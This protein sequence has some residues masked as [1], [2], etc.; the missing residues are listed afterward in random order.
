MR[1]VEV[2]FRLDPFAATLREHLSGRPGQHLVAFAAYCVQRLLPSY[3]PL[4]AA[5]Y[6]LRL[7][8][9]EPL[10]RHVAGSGLRPAEIDSILK[11]SAA[12]LGEKEE[13]DLSEQESDAMAFLDTHDDAFRLCR[14]PSVDAAALAA[15]PLRNELYQSLVGDPSCPAVQMRLLGAKELRAQSECTNSHPMTR[16]L[17]AQLLS[18]VSFLRDRASLAPADVAFVRSQAERDGM[19][20]RGAAGG[21]EGRS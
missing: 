20:W 5:G 2:H 6:A 12:V 10:W 21:G 19:P 8:A 1:D 17:E 11:A 3:E 7:D 14:S 13:D 9:P 16:A 15:S 4:A 18:V